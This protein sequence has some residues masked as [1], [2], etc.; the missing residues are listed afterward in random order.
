M[1]RLYYYAK[2]DDAYEGPFNKNEMVDFMED[3]IIFP[4][5]LVFKTGDVQWEQMAAHPDFSF[6]VKEFEASTPGIKNESVDRGD[7]GGRSQIKAQK[8]KLLLEIRGMLDVLWECQREAIMA[9]IM[10]T[11]LDGDMQ[12]LRDGYKRIFGELENK[13]VDYWRVDG[14]LLR[15]IGD[16]MRPQADYKHSIPLNTD[17]ASRMRSVRD[18]LQITGL[19]ALAG[20][21]CWKKQDDYL[22]VGQA[23]ILEERIKTYE[24][25]ILFEQATEI[26]ILVPALKGCKRLRRRQRLNALERLLILQHSPTENRNMN[27][28]RGYNE[29]DECLTYIKGELEELATDVE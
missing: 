7:E 24:T 29:I 17:R 18:W 15:V 16:Q 6:P 3:A 12:S 26:R 11:K 2:L 25:H 13:A 14:R 27:G 19:S 28:H 4:S 20:C 23:G 10:D 8:P 1:K 21:Y 22:Y 9:R 5:T